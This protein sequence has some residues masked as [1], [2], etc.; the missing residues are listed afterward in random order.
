MIW[1]KKKV[2]ILSKVISNKKKLIFKS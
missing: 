1:F 2:M